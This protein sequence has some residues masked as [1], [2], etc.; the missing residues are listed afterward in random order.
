MHSSST[1]GNTLGDPTILKLL[2]S[3]MEEMVRF[4]MHEALVSGRVKKVFDFKEYLFDFLLTQ[5]GLRNIA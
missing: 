3:A 2:E 4:E 1:V 5:Y